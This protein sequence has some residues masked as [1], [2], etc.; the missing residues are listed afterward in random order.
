LSC[1]RGILGGK[2]RVEFGYNRNVVLKNRVS[3]VKGGE[4]GANASEYGSE[5]VPC[6]HHAPNV[7]RFTV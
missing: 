4:A 6:N 2:K 3:E 7:C 5:C 1:C